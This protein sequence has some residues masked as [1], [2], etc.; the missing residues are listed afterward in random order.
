MLVCTV[1]SILIT[2]L[3]CPRTMLEMFLRLG[4]QENGTWLS[5]VSY[6]SLTLPT[7]TLFPLPQ[8]KHNILR[9]R[10]E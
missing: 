1:T 8:T 3:L 6:S 10:W 7:L 2:K 9:T 4:K 5:T